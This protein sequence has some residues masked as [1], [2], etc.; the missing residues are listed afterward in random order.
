MGK[1]AVLK[2][3]RGSFASGFPV[4]LRLGNEGEPATLELDGS[5]PSS[6]SLVELA[7]TWQFSYRSRG[8]LSF[9][10]LKAPSAQVTR[11]RSSLVTVAKDW[12]EVMND[13]LNSD[14]AFQPIRDQL[15]KAISSGEDV[16]LVIQAEQLELWQLPWHLWNLLQDHS[17]ADVTFSLAAFAAPV[18]QPQSV[19][20]RIRILVLLGDS[21][22]IDIQTDLRLLTQQLPQAEIYIPTEVQR[23]QLCND[24][25]QQSWDILF[26][27]GHSSSQFNEGRFYLDQEIY[28]TIDDLRYALQR[29][30]A[31]GLQL[32]IF[33]SCDG[34]ELARAL[35]DIQL[36]AAI[37]MRER[38]PD[39]AAQ[40]FL[41]YFLD[42]FAHTQQ[43]LHLAV[44]E[45]REKLHTALDDKYPCASWLP[46]FCQSPASLPVSWYS[47]S[48][49]PPTSSLIGAQAK[50]DGS[51]IVSPITSNIT[52]KASSQ[53]S[54]TRWIVLVMSFVVAS[55]VMGV[56]SLGGLRGLELKM[57]D[58][59]MLLRPFEGSD[60]RLVV[61]QITDD[62]VQEQIRNREPGDGS[63][64]DR[65]LK[66]LLKILDQHQ[67]RVI[68][69]DLLRDQPITPQHPDLHTRLL[70][71][72]KAPIIG[73]C[74]HSDF[75]RNPPTFG[76]PRPPS[77]P[78]ERTGFSDLTYDFDK[79]I[80][81]QLL[82]L[83][84][85]VSR[86][87][88]SDS[89]A[90]QVA[91][92]HLRKTGIKPKYLPDN[93]LQLGLITFNRLENH[94]AGYQN[95]SL[96]NPKINQIL[97]NYRPY[98]KLEQ[99]A[100]SIPLQKVLDQQFNPS[101]IKDRIVLIGRTDTDYHL[102]PYAEQSALQTP[103]VYIHAQAVSQI[104][105]AVLDERRL[106]SWMP[107]WGDFLWIWIWAAAGGILTWRTVF[108]HNS[109][110]LRG[111]GL[112]L[113]IALLYFWCWFFILWI[114]LLFPL[115]P[116]LIAFLTTS[117]LTTGLHQLQLR[118][119][120]R[121]HTS[122]EHTPNSIA[123][124]NHE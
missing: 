10:Q 96:V 19:K 36:P 104:L 107:A 51:A 59:L 101:F 120:T 38:I 5:L 40:K 92:H 35:A 112:L 62:D 22:N 105:A 124:F 66:K 77:I 82:K 102:T 37:V 98:Q 123:N 61:I 71:S 79:V 50:E 31:N 75:Q 34:L 100:N 7:E 55:G 95:S 25:W 45:A 67:P 116:A 12:V 57:F 15:L 48:S 58:H 108:S 74:K 54:I 97:L 80:R 2:F 110:W 8:I 99:I 43:P 13:W 64:R 60:P 20:N 121:K 41:H 89:F 70:D 16:R 18:V 21:T 30:I 11:Q 56:R 52:P 118:Q 46:I 3:G 4:T 47:L 115:V 114:T 94:A 9:R 73:I 29:A 91:V 27:A 76:T 28:L 117:W 44:R 106:V 83:D 72:Q 39:E 65:T 1:L 49:P 23:E 69:I 86:C 84:L 6:P 24:L 17:N 78:I 85:P 26:F 93:T 68:G 103:G 90:L 33:N 109:R 88:S 53:P 111:V 87:E 122:T 113:G 63:L 81:R 32:A 119:F 42:T 14:R